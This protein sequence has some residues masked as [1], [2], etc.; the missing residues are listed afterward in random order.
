MT[1]LLFV[2]YV[3]TAVSDGKLVRLQV[4]R[5]QQKRQQQTQQQQDA[6]FEVDNDAPE[7]PA[8]PE[9]AEV[10]KA[11][12]YASAT[13][14]FS[15]ALHQNM[16]EAARVV[17]EELST[18]RAREEEEFETLR[19]QERDRKLKQTAL[20]SFFSARSS[21]NTSNDIITSPSSPTTVPVSE[22]D[23]T[24]FLLNV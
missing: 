18:K 4:Q 5:Q 11:S 12:S 22:V 21:S 17:N 2:E 24:T 16:L 13:L 1:K 10:S 14:A 3:P 7:A 19:N 15:R 20:S 23:P 8:V 9:V 6:R